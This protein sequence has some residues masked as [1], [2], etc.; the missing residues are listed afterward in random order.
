MTPKFLTSSSLCTSLSFPRDNIIKKYFSSELIL[1]KNEK[2]MMRN[3]DEKI[4]KKWREMV[5]RKNE[6]LWWEMMMTQMSDWWFSGKEADRAAAVSNNWHMK[7]KWGNFSVIFSCIQDI[8]KTFGFDIYDI[9]REKKRNKI[10]WKSEK[11]HFSCQR[12]MIFSKLP[13]CWSESKGRSIAHHTSPVINS[14]MANHPH[15]NWAQ[16]IYKHYILITMKMH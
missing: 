8:C 15:K 9:L 16:E 3:D 13:S 12:M 10:Q 2:K 7:R 5:M 6:I 1:K 4:W 14:A 11:S